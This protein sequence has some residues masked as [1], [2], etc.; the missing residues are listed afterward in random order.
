[1]VRA[2][3]RCGCGA[4]TTQVV[5]R[6]NRLGRVTSGLRACGVCAA[7]AIAAGAEHSFD[8]DQPVEPFHNR[9]EKAS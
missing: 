3:D 1:M 5:V 8:L 7:T 2:A 9:Q 4:R 6:R